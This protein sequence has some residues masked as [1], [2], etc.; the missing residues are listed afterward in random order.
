VE[1]RPAVWSARSVFERRP[2]PR[3][4][5]IVLNA[6]RAHPGAVRRHTRRTVE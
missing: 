4:A 6:R 5:E 1:R 2:R 3:A